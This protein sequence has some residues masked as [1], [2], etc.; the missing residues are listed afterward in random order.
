[1]AE[2]TD[3]DLFLRSFSQ[4]EDA[5]R[6]TM[7]RLITGTTISKLSHCG[8]PDFLKIRHDGIMMAA[9]TKTSNIIGQSGHIGVSNVVACIAFL[10]T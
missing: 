9:A 2:D 8:Y 4:P 5:S 3:A 7:A 1:M 6:Y 10:L